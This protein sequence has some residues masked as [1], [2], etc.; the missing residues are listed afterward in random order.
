MAKLKLNEVKKYIEDN[1][2]SFHEA[3]EEGLEKLKLSTILLKKNPYLF[4]AKNILTSE[5]FVRKLVDAYLSSQEET[6]FGTFLERLAIF[7]CNK[8]YSGKKSPAEGLDL[9]FEKQ[10]IIY[11]VAVKSGT[12]WGNSS[13]VARMKENF[14]QAKQRLRTN[15]KK[16]PVEAINGCCYGRVT[17]IDKGEYQKIAGQQFWEF[18][19]D[20]IDLYTEIIEP[21]GHRAKERNE[22][23]DESYARMLNIFTVQFSNEFCVDGAINWNKLV[24]FNSGKEK[25]K[26]KI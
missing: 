2:G 22:A 24:K 11:V 21:L 19:S 18:I 14:R 5:M 23:F 13:Q 17:K 20:N 12:N 10:N 16:I 26:V 7:V 4:K 3:R 25:V 9:E 1:I 6:M 15:A 8:V